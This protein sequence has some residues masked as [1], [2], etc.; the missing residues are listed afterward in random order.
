[1]DNWSQL[2]NDRSKLTFPTRAARF[3]KEYIE[4]LMARKQ[5]T[6]ALEFVES[7]RA[8]L[9]AEKSGAAESASFQTIAKREGAVLLSYWLAPAHSYVWAVASG[10]PPKAFTLP[11]EA[12]ICKAVDRYS[13]A[14][15]QSADPAA[16]H[17]ESG[18]ALYNTLLG[19]LKIQREMPV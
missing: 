18:R 9:L 3:Y 12:E 1:D 5:I 2:I 14:I 8:R 6:P 17:S 15:L 13:A 7:H 4:F 10:A 19:Q 16:T 11:P